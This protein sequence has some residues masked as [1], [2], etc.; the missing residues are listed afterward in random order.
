M[1]GDLIEFYILG[2]IVLLIIV[3]LVFIAK[4][5]KSTRKR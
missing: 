2:G 1:K 4:E 5:E 3:F